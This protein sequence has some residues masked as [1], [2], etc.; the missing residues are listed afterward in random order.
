[1]NA[2]LPFGG[3]GASGFGRASGE[4]GFLSYCNVQ[5]VM[6]ARLHPRREIYWYP[7]TASFA[8][9]WKKLVGLYHGSLG[10]KVRRLFG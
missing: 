9:L 7:Y 1:M 6:T 2:R 3:V 10:E 8:K 4:L 5:G